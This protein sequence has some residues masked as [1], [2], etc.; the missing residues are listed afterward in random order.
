MMKCLLSELRDKEIISM[1]DGSRLGCPEDAEL[2]METGQITKL[3]VPGRLRLF[4]LFGREEDLIL[5]WSDI[6]RFGID[7]ILIKN[8]QLCQQKRLI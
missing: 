4:G 2:D 8:A 1:A 5:P 7:T 3:I 6:H